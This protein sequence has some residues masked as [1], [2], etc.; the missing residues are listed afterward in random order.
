MKDNHRH[1]IRIHAGVDVAKEHLDLFIEG[2]SK[3]RRFANTKAG[4]RR[5]LQIIAREAAAI[6][7]APINARIVFEPSGGYEIALRDQALSAGFC[8]CRINARQVREF[9][10]A[11]GLLEKSDDLDAKILCSY[12][13]TYQPQAGKPPRKAVQTLSSQIRRRAQILGMLV[14]SRQHLEKAECRQADADLR[15]EI[16]SLITLLE[17]RVERIEKQLSKTVATDAELARQ[18]EQLTAVKGVGPLTAWTLLAEMP[19]L[20]EMRP[21]EAAKMAGLAPM[22][23]DSGKHRGQRRITGGRAIVRHALFN[24]ARSAIRFNQQMKELYE[25]LR[26]AGKIHSVAIVAVMRRILKVAC[27]ILSKPDFVPAND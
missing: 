27:L 18:F 23:C 17:R 4:R 3:S 8:A 6:D 15:R 5:L 21:S 20:A 13:Q 16:R 22:I 26:T 9:A 1:D 24:A 19:E 11:G 14:Q 12:G 2:W 7:S 25:R 10:R